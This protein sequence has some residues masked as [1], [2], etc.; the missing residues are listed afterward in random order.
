MTKTLTPDQRVNLDAESRAIIFQGASVNQLAEMFRLKTPDVAR[1]LGDLRPIGTGRQNNPLYDIRDA[2]ARLIR[3][4]V[5]PE[6]IEAYMRRVNPR[7]LPPITNKILWEGM[8]ARRRYEEQVGDLWSTVDVIAVA[9]EAFQSIRMSLLLVPDVL[10]DNV[11]L[12]ESQFSVV[13][14]IVD[15]ALEDARLKL[16]IDLRKPR[17]TASVEEEL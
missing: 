2:A 15:A 1:R 10:R 14:G 5:T 8:T 17:E 4:P 7:D 3:I 12:T 6:M 9:S 13:Q 16:V 11:G